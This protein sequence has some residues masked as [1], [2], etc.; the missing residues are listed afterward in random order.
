M[1]TEN[2]QRQICHDNEGKVE[3][4][5]GDTGADWGRAKNTL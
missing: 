3:A 4:L 5:H 1:G 2:E